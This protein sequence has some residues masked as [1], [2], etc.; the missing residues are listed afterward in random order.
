[1]S[2]SAR[3]KLIG[4]KYCGGCNP[5]IDRVKLVEEIK[6]LLPP[7]FIFTKE[8]SSKPWAIGILVCGCLTACADKPDFKILAGKWIIVAGNSVDQNNAPEKELAKI[9]VDKITGMKPQSKLWEQIPQQPA[10]D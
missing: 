8:T 1:M 4:V 5:T 3:M 6:K 7:E 9:I 2:S 10:G